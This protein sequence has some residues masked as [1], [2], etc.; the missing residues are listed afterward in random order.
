[1]KLKAWA[2]PLDMPVL[3]MIADHTYVTSSDGDEW[4]CW[5]RSSG[6][7]KICEK[8]ASKKITACIAGDNGK[9]G[10]LV[11]GIN[12][13]CHQTAN[14]LL[15]DTRATVS[16]AKGYAASWA[17]F[18]PYG[19]VSPGGIKDPLWIIRE[20]KCGIKPWSIDPLWIAETDTTDPYF[21]GLATVYSQI[22]D[23]LE[24][25]TISLD[26]ATLQLQMGELSALVGSRL[27]TD[28][29]ADKINALA[30]YRNELAKEYEMSMLTSSGNEALIAKNANTV[31]NN[32]LAKAATT[33]TSEEYEA[34]FDC[35]PGVE[36]IVVDPEIAANNVEIK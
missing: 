8:D 1:M 7:R 31:L 15:R 28:L 17:L 2:I 18:G 21:E 19:K 4:G 35:K 14:R 25:G 26:Q 9:A 23:G 32:F 24:K 27:E 6:G 3:K 33:L 10:V 5:G 36:V 22:Y 12:G 30:Q 16:S 13:V 20:T 34:I 11:Y 29:G